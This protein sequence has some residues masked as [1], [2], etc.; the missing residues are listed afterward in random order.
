MGLP[1][2]REFKKGWGGEADVDSGPVI[3]SI[4]GAASLVGQRT[5]A[6]YGEQATA[7]GLRNSIEAFGFP[8]EK[9]NEKKYIL[10]EL[11]M[12]DAF[13]AWANSVENNSTHKLISNE[14][15]RR[16]FQLYSVLIIFAPII[17]F[18]LRRR[19][20]ARLKIKS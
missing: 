8:L 20:K 17:I 7:I 3:F 18:V 16:N 15:W 5:Y 19:R 1:G 6:V 2:V 4:G 9:N 12:A 13:I 11:V 10:G 14:S